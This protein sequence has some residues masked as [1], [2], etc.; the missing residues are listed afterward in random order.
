MSSALV[1]GMKQLPTEAASI[2]SFSQ[3]IFS[4]FDTY[5]WLY[6]FSKAPCPFLETLMIEGEG[7]GVGG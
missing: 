3:N 7:E 2:K 5:L 4:L 1:L 6:T